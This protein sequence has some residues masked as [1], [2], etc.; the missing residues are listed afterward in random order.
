MSLGV[1]TRGFEGIIRGFRGDELLQERL[2]DL[3]VV[4]GERISVEGRTLF[5]D[6]IIA[7]RGARIALRKEE[8]LCILV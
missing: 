7:V 6:Y 4:R 8:A 2:M 5:G 1:K 3:G